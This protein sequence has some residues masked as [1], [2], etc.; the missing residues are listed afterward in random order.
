MLL[1]NERTNAKIA[2]NLI[3]HYALV[4]QEIILMFSLLI[5]T[6]KN[7]HLRLQ[8]FPLTL[9]YFLGINCFKYKR[10][11]VFE[12]QSRQLVFKVGLLLGEVE[13]R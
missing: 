10:Q 2:K 1:V 13:S 12:I 11:N 4:L 6:V 7:F 9:L 3:L 8:G 5:L